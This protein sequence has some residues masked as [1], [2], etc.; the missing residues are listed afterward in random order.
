MVLFS[1]N[2]AL[3]TYFLSRGR[4][5]LIVSSGIVYAGYISVADNHLPIVN[6][7]IFVCSMECVPTETEPCL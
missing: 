3:V 6:V 5:S 2:F 1:E 7:R 4:C